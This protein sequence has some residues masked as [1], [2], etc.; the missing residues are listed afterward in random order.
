MERGELLALLTQALREY[1]GASSNPDGGLP[2]IQIHI[3]G[4]IFIGE[5][6]A[7]VAGLRLIK[8][9]EPRSNKG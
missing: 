7:I 2:S 9:A 5:P 4:P 8:E 1:Q 3:H 6:T